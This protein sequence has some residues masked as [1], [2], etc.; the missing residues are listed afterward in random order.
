MSTIAQHWID[1][2]WVSSDS[3]SDS[4]EPRHRR[5]S[6]T[7]VRRR[8]DRGGRGESQRHADVRPLQLGAHP[9]LRNQALLEM[10]TRF[11]AHAAELGTLVTR[12]NGK[13]LTEGLF[14]GGSPSPT[15][16][17]NAA[18]TLAIPVSSPK[19]PPAN[20]SRPMRSPQG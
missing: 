12:E 7:V 11:A 8:R 6:R 3:V 17:H 4:L 15:L 14:E 2:E 18:M 16:L 19:S 20:G 5:R 10:A 1:G 9:G 13:K